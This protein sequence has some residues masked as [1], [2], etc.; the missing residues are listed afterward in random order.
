M[1]PGIPLLVKD[2]LF[3]REQ[4]QEVETFK[5]LEISVPS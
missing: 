3:D 5:A 1:Q 2:Q 4:P